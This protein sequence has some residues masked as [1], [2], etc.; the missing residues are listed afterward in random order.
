MSVLE[1][2][3]SP[4]PQHETTSTLRHSNP[5]HL[6]LSAWLLLL[7]RRHTTLPVDA[8]AMSRTPADILPQAAE[9]QD[10][11]LR[12]SLYLPQFLQE[13]IDSSKFPESVLAPRVAQ[14]GIEV[15]LLGCRM[16]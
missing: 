12:A 13:P 9:G 7:M 4:A 8:P 16:L 11:H 3:A 2:A 15:C 1:T 5:T 14:R 6:H 10:G